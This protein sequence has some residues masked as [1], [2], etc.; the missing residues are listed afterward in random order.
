MKKDEHLLNTN[1]PYEI[2]TKTTIV[3]FEELTTEILYELL[4][5][6]TR[7]VWHL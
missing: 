6:G 2:E 7:A 4:E 1:K 3:S 5:N